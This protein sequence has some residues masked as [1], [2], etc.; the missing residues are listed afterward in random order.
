[1]MYKQILLYVQTFLLL[2]HFFTD[3]TIFSA[4]GWIHDHFSR[5]LFVLE[6]IDLMRLFKASYNKIP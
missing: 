1:M 5:V 4:G 6:E 2:F 3:V